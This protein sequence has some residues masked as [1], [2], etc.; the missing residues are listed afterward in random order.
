MLQSPGPL[1][2]IHEQFPDEILRCLIRQVPLL[3]EP[4]R[5]IADHYFRLV[6]RK[7]IEIHEYLAQMVLCPRR[8]DTTSRGSSHDR[9]RFSG[10]GAVAVRPGRPVYGVLQ[11]TGNR[12]IMFRRGKQN[13]VRRVYPFFQFDDLRQWLLLL[14]LV[15]ARDV[16]CC[17]LTKTSPYKMP[18]KASF[19][20]DT[21]NV[22]QKNMTQLLRFPSSVKR[23]PAI[24]TWMKKHAG[25]LGAIAK[26]WFEV[27]RK[28]GEEVR[29][30]LHDGHPTA[31]VA[32]AAFA[33]VNVFKAHVHDVGFFEVLR[34]PIRRACWRALASLCA[35]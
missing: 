29:E 4:I 16:S 28:C 9:G 32:D 5:G 8:A 12:I 18:C 1:H 31:C 15:E 10:P 35:M 22:R 34:L 19:R 2:K 7:D 20:I 30:L 17:R 21:W 27:M 26:H 13:R 33:Y 24:E 23:D 25:E 14:V 11:H 6:E 3:I